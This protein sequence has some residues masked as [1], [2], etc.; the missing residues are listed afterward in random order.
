MLVGL[1]KLVGRWRV[2]LSNAAFLSSPETRLWGETSI[3]WLENAFVVMRSTMRGGPPESTMVLGRSDFA[4]SYTALYYDARGVS[5]IYEMTFD[6][7]FWQM[8]RA[9]PDFHQR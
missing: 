6:G 9:D 7:R 5:R 4:E 8:F 2:E 3:H 1:D